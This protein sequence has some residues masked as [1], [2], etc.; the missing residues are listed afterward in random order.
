MPDIWDDQ[1]FLT[2]KEE[3]LGT[4]ACWVVRQSPYI[5]PDNLQE[6]LFEFWGEFDGNDNDLFAD[7]TF[8]ETNCNDLRGRIRETF[9]MCTIVLKWN[10][11][12]LGNVFVS[13]CHKPE[14]DYNSIDLDALARN[15]AHS[16][17]LEA[18]YQRYHD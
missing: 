9:E 1:T 14:P 16:I 10:V 4:L 3:I 12:K 8:F 7:I 15:V 5:I 18:K 17:T 2:S 6:G 13:G 11:A